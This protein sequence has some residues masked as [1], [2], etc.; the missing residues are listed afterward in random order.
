MT[1]EI[2]AGPRIIH[3]ARPLPEYLLRVLPGTEYLVRAN[4]NLIP[5]PKKEYSGDA[6][7][8][9]VRRYWGCPPGWAGGRP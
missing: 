2:P 4:R 9:G 6:G 3:G 8:I 1:R 7:G 5:A